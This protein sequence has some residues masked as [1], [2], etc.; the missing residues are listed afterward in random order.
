MFF[1]AA[2]P[3][4]SSRFHQY[5]VNFARQNYGDR[6]SIDCQ[7]DEQ[8]DERRSSF[9]GATKGANHQRRT[10][11]VHPPTVCG[12]LGMTTRTMLPTALC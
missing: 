4:C 2:I 1:V 7:P 6:V 9:V 3:V 5:F 8:L 12:L 11:Q 10:D